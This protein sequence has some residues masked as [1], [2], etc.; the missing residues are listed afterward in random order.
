[1]DRDGSYVD[2]LYLKKGAQV[3]LLTNLDQEGGLVNGSR[4]IVVDFDLANKKYPI[5]QFLNGLKTIEPHTWKSDHDEPIERK[6]IPLRLAYA[7]TIHKAQGATLDCAL[8]DIGPST[9]EYGQAYVALSRIKSLESLYIH[10]VARSAFK[11]HP[12]VLE[13][14]AKAEEDRT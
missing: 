6:Q 2:T 13:F 1:M 4:G 8:I 5:V 12:L 7:L 11:A 10:D 14:Y 9:F 3:M